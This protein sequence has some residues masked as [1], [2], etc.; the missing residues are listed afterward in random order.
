M[1]LAAVYTE[2]NYFNKKFPHENLCVHRIKV[3][4]D[5]DTQIHRKVNKHDLTEV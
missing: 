3:I 5:I 1:K 2:W 4:A